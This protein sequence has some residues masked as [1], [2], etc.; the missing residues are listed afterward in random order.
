[1]SPCAALNLERAGVLDAQARKKEQSFKFSAGFA[2][3]G[4]KKHIPKPLL[5]N[6]IESFQRP[7]SRTS[8]PAITASRWRKMPHLQAAGLRDLQRKV[9]R[10]RV[11]RDLKV[12][13]MIH[14]NN[15]SPLTAT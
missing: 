5:Q 14:S 13:H 7:G 2:I 10:T 1:M 8:S 11:T 12:L 3:P 15:N 9:Q 6:N 4:K